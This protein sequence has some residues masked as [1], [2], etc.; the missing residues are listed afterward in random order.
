MREN[1]TRNT[2]KP[3]SDYGVIGDCHS[4]A[5]VGLDGS[6]DWCC[7]PRF[8]SPSVFAAILDAGKGGYFA[9]TPQGAYSATQRYLDDANILETRFEAKGG[10]CTLTD[11]MPLYFR[12]D[13]HPVEFHQIIRL[14]RCEAGEIALQINYA[15]R[16]DYA[17][18]SVKLIA[19]GNQVLC[20]FGNEKLELRPLQSH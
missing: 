6:I 5:L 7:F 17:R 9:I 16:P 11:C 18:Q 13:G 4:A 12:P 15:P 3:I 10:A 1:P 8:D 2:Y 19:Q 20:N 14:L